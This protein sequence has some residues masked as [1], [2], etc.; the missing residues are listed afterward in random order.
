[1]IE[2][3]LFGSQ[4]T[5]TFLCAASYCVVSDLSPALSAAVIGPVLGGSTALMTTLP[6]AAPPAA[7][8][9]EEQAAA[10]RPV[11]ASAAAVRRDGL[12]FAW[13]RPHLW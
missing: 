1:M 13:Q 11:T 8:P 10:R 12:L 7:E 4:S 6:A 5:V 9:P 2:A 3:V